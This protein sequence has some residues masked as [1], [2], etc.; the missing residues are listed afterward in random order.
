[1]DDTKKIDLMLDSMKE[2]EKNVTLA[3]AKIKEFYTLQ[4]KIAE[5]QKEVKEIYKRNEKEMK[6][7]EKNIV[8]GMRSGIT[9]RIAAARTREKAME[10][11]V[12]KTGSV[13]LSWMLGEVNVR[14]FTPTDLDN[15]KEQFINFKTRMTYYYIAIPAMVLLI[16]HNPTFFRH[17]HWSMIFLQVFLLYYYTTLSIRSL[18]LK[19][20][21]S[22]MMDW[23]IY[24]H[25][26]SMLMAIVF[27][28][29]PDAPV[30][31]TYKMQYVMYILFQGFVQLLQNN[32]Q[33]ARHYTSRAL[34]HAGSMDVPMTETITEVPS[35]LL[36]V[37]IYINQFLQIY[38]G[39]SLLYTM[40]TEL[41]L[42]Q[43][44]GNYKEELQ[45]FTIGFLVITV[46]IGNFL[47][48]TYTLLRKKGFLLRG[49]GENNSP[50]ADTKEE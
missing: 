20:N 21:G 36:V 2:V 38:N 3:E 5:I 6:F 9:S 34:G 44:L 31:N 41:R 42:L 25:Y 22:K 16:Q 28:T 43:P 26:L 33:R 1:M 50:D 40:F 45:C 27:L 39:S 19:M 29:W 4:V 48:T 14:V 12:P 49:D 32:Y 15:I 7:V 10:R 13:F 17:T 18:V 37:V 11:I 35:L 47:A 23:W 8:S 30:Y 24:H 46:G